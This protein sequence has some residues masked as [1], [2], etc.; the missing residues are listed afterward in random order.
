M[1]RSLR[2]GGRGRKRWMKS[3]RCEEGRNKKWVTTYKN[4]ETKI[5]WGWTSLSSCPAPSPMCMVGGCFLTILR[6]ALRCFL[7]TEP[8]LEAQSCCSRPFLWPTL[9]HTCSQN[10]TTLA[11]VLIELRRLPCV[12]RPCVHMCVRIEA[13]WGTERQGT[14]LRL[15]HFSWILETLPLSQRWPAEAAGLYISILYSSRNATI[16]RCSVIQLLKSECAG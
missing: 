14:K 3:Q 6:R 11:R 4:K 10:V 8:L 9:L 15:P 7:H 1:T 2:R 12:W 13:K 5:T 16:R